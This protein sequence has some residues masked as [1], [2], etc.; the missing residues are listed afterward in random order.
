[1]EPDPDRPRSPVR[2]E[3]PGREASDAPGDPAS[4]R[5]AS[6]RREWRRGEILKGIRGTPRQDADRE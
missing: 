5:V 6:G 2:T 1:M 3:A 4:L